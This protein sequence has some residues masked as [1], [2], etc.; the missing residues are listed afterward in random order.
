MGMGI[1]WTLA[2]AFF[3]C[4]AI[5]YWIGFARGWDQG[6]EFSERFWKQYGDV[7]GEGQREEKR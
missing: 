7:A 5:A 4:M 3:V 6:S 1:A 2:V